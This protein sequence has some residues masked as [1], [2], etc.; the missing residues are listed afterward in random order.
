VG[1]LVLPADARGLPNRDR[2]I[3]VTSDNL[4]RVADRCRSGKAWVSAVLFG[5]ESRFATGEPGAIEEGIVAAEKLRPQDF[6]IPS[7]PQISSKGTRREA[8]APIRSLEASVD[9]T[10]LHVSVELLRGAYATCLLRELMKSE[11]AA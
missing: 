2:T 9:E 7:I 10:G 8:L 5:A 6:L 1:D 4:E 3:E 11:S